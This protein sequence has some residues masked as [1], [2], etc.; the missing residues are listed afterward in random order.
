MGVRANQEGLKLND[1]HQILI[2]TDD[3][4]I[5]SGSIHAVKRK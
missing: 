2:Y 5:L 4:N 1:T 3:I